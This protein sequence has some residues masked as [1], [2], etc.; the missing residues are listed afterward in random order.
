MRPRNPPSIKIF[1]K[2]DPGRQMDQGLFSSRWAHPGSTFSKKLARDEW[3]CPICQFSNF[4]HRTQCLNCTASRQKAGATG[5]SITANTSKATPTANFIPPYANPTLPKQASDLFSS[6][7]APRYH[8][9]QQ[10]RQIWTRTAPARSSTPQRQ[11]LGLPYEVQHFILEMMRR[12]LEEAS[13]D[14][15]S[16]TIPQVL[17]EKA[18]DCSERVELAMWRDTLPEAVPASALVVISG[19]SFTQAL[20]DAVRLRNVGTHRQL[21]DNGQLRKMADWSAGLMVMYG[22]ETRRAKFEWLFD[23]LIAWDEGKNAEERRRKLEE[24]LRY[25]SERPLESMDW[26]PN[27]ESLEE[28]STSE[29]NSTYATPEAMDLD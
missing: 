21:C 5:P 25:I 1:T 14:F 8:Q 15:A 7:Y 13:F 16:R 2:Q 11:D 29:T 6:R 28:V 22:D 4:A 20:I 12:I 3:I 19:Y 27:S 9:P 18:W 23:E 26:S 17:A 10:P 24:A